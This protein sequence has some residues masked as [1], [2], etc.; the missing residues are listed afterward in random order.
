MTVPNVKID[1]RGWKMWEHGVPDSFY[2]IPEDAEPVKHSQIPF[3]LGDIKHVS[4]GETP[5][6]ILKRENRN[7]EPAHTHK[8][9]SEWTWS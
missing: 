6:K 2:Y 1:M 5:V 7:P 8:C 3:R 9:S 4:N